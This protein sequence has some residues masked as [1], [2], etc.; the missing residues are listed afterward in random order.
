MKIVAVFNLRSRLSARQRWPSSWPPAKP[1]AG[2]TRSW[3]RKERK[4]AHGA[5]EPAEDVDFNARGL[6]KSVLLVDADPQCSLT[7]FFTQ[8]ARP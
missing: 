3:T 4:R 8:R 7:G 2:L 5:D 1:A 6:G